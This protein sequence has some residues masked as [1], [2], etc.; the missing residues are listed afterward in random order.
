[1]I[2]PCVILTCVILTGGAILAG[3]RFVADV[4][5]NVVFV[6]F[7]FIIFSGLA[8]FSPEG[9]AGFLPMLLLLDVLLLFFGFPPSVLLPQ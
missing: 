3:V 2:L 7:A 8:R 4:F 9:R 6:V 1:M 5:L